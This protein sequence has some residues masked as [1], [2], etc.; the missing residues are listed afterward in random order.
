MMVSLFDAS[1]P[2]FQR[3]LE[4]LAGLVDAAEAHDEAL[5]QARL[6]PDMLP[7]AT[8]VVIAANFTLRA[9]FPLAGR[10]LP[11]YGEFPSTF[12]G[13]R[14][15]IAHAAAL[16]ASLTREEFERADASRLIESRA[17]EAVVALAPPA[18]LLQYALPN[19]FFHLSTAYAILRER[20]VA[21]GKA[22]FDGFHVYGSAS[23][24]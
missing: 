4:R 20:G 2:V 17:G 13:L 6:A 18:F 8:H 22:H 9:C 5:L 7:F 11:P 10:E 16:L 14:Q 19:F 24:R 23:Q 12:A 3:Y 1:V 15:H 21:L